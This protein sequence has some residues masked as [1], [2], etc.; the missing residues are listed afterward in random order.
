MMAGVYTACPEQLSLRSTMPQFLEYE[1]K[2]GSVIVGLQEEAKSRSRATNN[3]GGARYSMFV[4]LDGGIGVLVD[5]LKNKIGESNIKLN[6]K[7]AELRRNSSLWTVKLENGA[8]H[9]ADAV[10]VALPCPQ[11]ARLLASVNKELSCQLASI[12]YASSVVLN[13]LFR[14]KDIPNPLN[15]FGFVVPEIEKRQIIACSYSSVKFANRAPEDMVALRV[16]LGGALHGELCEVTEDAAVKLAAVDLRHY[17][18]IKAAPL[19]QKLTRFRESMP[20]YDVGHRQLV[21][22]LQQQLQQESGLYL[23]GN[24]YSGVG[25]P[26]CIASGDKAAKQALDSLRSRTE[27]PVA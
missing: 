25:I 2:Y 27:Q 24:G 12:R 18:G 11:A 20:Q 16:F 23:A 22:Q 4:S 15:G 6:S 19:W 7:V 1:A 21:E 17:L 13:L 26:D 8:V 5:A 3:D 9:E 10:V 14:R